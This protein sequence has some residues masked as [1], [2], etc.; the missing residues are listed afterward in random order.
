MKMKQTFAVL[1]L[2]EIQAVHDKYQTVIHQKDK[3]DKDFQA[4]NDANRKMRQEMGDIAIRFLTEKGISVD[5][6]FVTVFS[7]SDGSASLVVGTKEADVYNNATWYIVDPASGKIEVSVHDSS[8]QV[9]KK[10]PMQL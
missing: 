8:G 2:S 3:S 7:H 5:G 10:E 6:R 4:I 1:G 9:T